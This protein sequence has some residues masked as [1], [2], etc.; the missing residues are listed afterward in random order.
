MFPPLDVILVVPFFVRV[1]VL[2][3]VLPLTFR[4]SDVAFTIAPNTVPAKVVV[5]PVD[6]TVPL[7]I[8]P[9]V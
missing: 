3:N 7:L 9:E 1:T 8:V 4:A 6:V 5:A 2:L